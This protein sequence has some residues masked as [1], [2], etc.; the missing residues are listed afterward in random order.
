MTGR[1]SAAR[2]I[3]LASTMPAVDRRLVASARPARAFV[4]AAVAL[5]L[6]T[7][8]MVV[9]QAWLIAE[10]ISAAV[11]RGQGLQDLAGPLVALLAVIVTRAVLAW[12]VEAFAHRSSAAVKSQLRRAFLQRAIDLGPSWLGSRRAAQLETLGTRGLD[13]LD[14]YFARYLPQLILAVVVPVVVLVA[15]ATQDRVAAGIMMVTLPLIPLFMGVVGFSTRA[16]TARRLSA[17]QRLAGQFMDSVA[18]L[19]TLKIFG[20]AAS[21]A[22][23]V[24]LA[25]DALRRETLG[26]L[27]VAFMSSLVL[28]LLASLSVAVVAVAVGLRLVNGGLDFFTGLF[29]LVLAPE[30]YQPLRALAA[31]FHASADGVAAADQVFEVLETPQPEHGSC[32]AVPDPSEQPV[33]IEQATV[34]YPDQPEP[35]LTGFSLATDPGQIVALVGASGAGKSTVLGVLLGYV[36]LESGRVTI[37]DRDLSELDLTLWRTRVAWVPQ[38]PY[39]FAGSLA[40]NITLGRPH[41]PHSAID[42]AIASAGLTGLVA[43][44]PAGLDTILGE[45]GYGLSAGERQRV[46]LAR[47]FVMDAQLLVLDEPTANLDGDTEASILSVIRRM[48]PG[49]TVVMAAHRQ[50]LVAMA[51]RTVRLDGAR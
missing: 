35:V 47:A 37:G 14:A 44:L 17:L 3:A 5:G 34:R 22:R 9:T 41:A 20:A 13:G 1:E 32:R 11:Q 18:G 16:R 2:R 7:A 28:E 27:R 23:R 15:V 29:V 26:T 24:G 45:R 46:A 49:R 30:A 21:Q 8:A 10:L 33:R 40:E 43:R 36:P 25:T 50:P 19:T 42:T 39:L 51:D 31:E 6:L 38:R 4:A 12:S 48:S